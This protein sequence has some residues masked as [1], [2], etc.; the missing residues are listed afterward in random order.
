MV[1]QGSNQAGAAEGWLSRQGGGGDGGNSGGQGRGGGRGGSKRGGRES[2]DEDEDE[3]VVDEPSVD[4]P[5]GIVHDLSYEATGPQSNR[6]S[7]HRKRMYR[8]RLEM[9]LT[10]D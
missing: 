2:E 4:E 3:D 7:S 9:L 8:G 1:G 10:A 5:S 6:S